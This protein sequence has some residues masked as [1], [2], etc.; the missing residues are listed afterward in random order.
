MFVLMTFW[1]Y[2]EFFYSKLLGSV[3]TTFR[4]DS[5]KTLKVLLSFFSDLS[6]ICITFSKFGTY[7]RIT[8]NLTNFVTVTHLIIK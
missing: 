8:L 7:E 1:D 4:I 5:T 6:D 3:I 2:C